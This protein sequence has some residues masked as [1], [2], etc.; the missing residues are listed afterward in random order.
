MLEAYRKVCYKR[1]SG[2]G[3][4]HEFF[5]LVKKSVIEEHLQWLLLTISFQVIF[6]KLFEILYCATLH[7]SYKYL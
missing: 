1:D 3:V 4:F 2:T 6:C 7:F 5:D